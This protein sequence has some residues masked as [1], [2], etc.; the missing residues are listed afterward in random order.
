VGILAFA[1]SDIAFVSSCAA[2][3]RRSVTPVA[4]I[5]NSAIVVIGDSEKTLT[6]SPPK[7]LALSLVD[8]WSIECSGAKL[9]RKY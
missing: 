5:A 1:A 3:S 8:G 9:A 2:E 4:E 6:L 7:A